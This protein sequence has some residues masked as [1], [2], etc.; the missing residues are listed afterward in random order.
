MS[1]LN[2]HALHR[3]SALSRPTLCAPGLPVSG[4][5]PEPGPN[6]APTSH[7]ASQGLQPAW[8]PAW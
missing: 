8:K 1:P 3:A 2:K 5:S 4:P 6:P 7:V